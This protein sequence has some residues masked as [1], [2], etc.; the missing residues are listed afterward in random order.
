MNKNINIPNEP[1]DTAFCWMPDPE[2]EIPDKDG[3]INACIT[4]EFAAPRAS[5]LKTLLN[6]FLGTAMGFIKAKAGVVRVLLPMNKPCRLSVL[7]D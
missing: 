4:Q 6:T 2:F 3:G 7:S 1:D 5:D